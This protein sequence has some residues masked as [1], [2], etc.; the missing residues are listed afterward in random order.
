MKPGP[1][2]GCALMDAPS[3]V[4]RSRH[5]FSPLWNALTGLLPE[6][7][8]GMETRGPHLSLNAAND[9]PRSRASPV[10]LIMCTGG[11]ERSFLHDLHGSYLGKPSPHRR[12]RR[13]QAE[14]QL[15]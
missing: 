11:A 10:S 2:W 15:A 6:K 12:S 8:A 3:P 14:F 13:S 7:L 1:S 4:R 9:K 5:N